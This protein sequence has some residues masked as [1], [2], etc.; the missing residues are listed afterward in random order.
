MVRAIT[1]GVN[2]AVV[3]HYPTQKL[4]EAAFD[5]AL[6]AGFVEVV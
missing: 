5:L 1:R 4:A 6:R 3:E 2:G